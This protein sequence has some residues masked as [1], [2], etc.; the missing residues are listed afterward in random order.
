M[1][2]GGKPTGSVWPARLSNFWW[3]VFRLREPS[4]K[5][6]ADRFSCRELRDTNGMGRTG[7]VVLRQILEAEGLTFKCGCAGETRSVRC[8]VRGTWNPRR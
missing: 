2:R 7:M 5:D 4:V 1:T 8:S 6:V 3:N